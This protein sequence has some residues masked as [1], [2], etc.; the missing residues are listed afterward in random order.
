MA[1]PDSSAPAPRRQGAL[2]ALVVL[3]LAALL[4][5]CSS[6]PRGATQPKSEGTDPTA[7]GTAPLGQLAPGEPPTPLPVEADDASWGR[8]DA[9]VTVIAYLDFQCPFCA[10][11]FETLQH[12]KEEYGPER[13]RIVIKHLPLEFH[14]DALPAAVAAQ[15]VR[16]TAGNDAF[17]AY[18]AR[19]MSNPR[20]LDAT[21][22]AEHAEEVG[23][24]RGV[25]NEQVADE[26]TF[27]AV[28]HDMELAQ[29]L[30]ITGTPAFYVNGA[31]LQG[32]QPI[33]S[34]REL[35]DQE[36][37]ALATRLEQGTP[38]ASA[39]AER[40]KR[41]LHVSISEQLLAK[42]PTTYRAVVD[43]S[44][45]LGEAD[46]LVTL[47]EF[48]DFECPFCKRVRPT[49]DQL[50]K[51]YGKK[52]R[53]VFKHLPLPFHQQAR[54]AARLAD[55]VYRERGSAAFFQAADRLFAAPTLSDDLLVSVGKDLGLSEAQARTALAATS[56]PRLDR[57]AQLASDL[58]A[59]GTP[60]FFINGRRVTGAQPL[61]HFEVFVD[62]ALAEAERLVASGIEPSRVYEHLMRNAATPGVPEKVSEETL[63]R[64]AAAKR[65]SRGPEGAPVVIHVFSDFQCPYCR[66][67]EHTVAALASKYSDRVRIVWHNLPLPFHEQARPAA[68][69]AE[70]AFLQGGSKAFW[71]MHA[72]L[73]NLDG[74]GPALARSDLEAHAKKAGLDLTRFQRALDTRAH[75]GSIVADEEL[76]EELGIRGTPS[77]LVGGYLVKGALPLDHF[78]RLVERVLAESR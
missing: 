34:F 45:T 14:P 21:S 7:G 48:S 38:W 77:F 51:K 20:A 64:L 24:D 54:P 30:G 29:R 4:T 53:V 33:D 78:E 67:A 71:K 73:F 13:L 56:S 60:H 50:K 42:D 36:A 59:N 32:A 12:L 23:L 37:A 39:Y 57:D 27:R 62:A 47:V 41:N 8:S 63:K 1:R 16:N 10:R 74:E 25:Y 58:E 28:V 17:F 6:T 69:A 72:A 22:L 31:L 5:G 76:A 70:E 61:G 40:V 19:L 75:D 2:F 3:L 9:P 68:H 11:G 26:A 35:I 49:I 44:P 46:A 43:G 18:A 66:S 55:A 52:L 15:A 65:P